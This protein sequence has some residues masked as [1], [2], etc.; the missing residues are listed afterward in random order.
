[1][2]INDTE[3]NLP[4]E[5]KQD[6]PNKI[7][8]YINELQEFKNNE[9]TIKEINFEKE[10]IVFSNGKNEL[11]MNLQFIRN[12]NNSQ[13]TTT[14]NSNETSEMNT[15][16]KFNGVMSD[17]SN[18]NTLTDK[19]NQLGQKQRQSLSGGNN[20]NIF[21]SSKYSDTSSLNQTE[22]SNYSNITPVIYN[23]R[24]DNFSDTSVL[25][26]NGGGLDNSENSDT[27]RSVSELKDRKNKFSNKNT[28]STFKSNL[29]MG[30]F[31]KS[32]NQSGGTRSQLDLKK[33][34]IDAGINS[35]STSS[36]CE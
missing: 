29:D 24:S 11:K 17:T 1:M 5:M 27:L 18:G 32:Q 20:K 3:Q 4:N 14:E 10:E 15:E 31:R 12:K 9:F 21:K 36:I 7:V 30:I 25:G 2:N 19:F 34:M 22:L 13:F 8:G 26:Q 23:N 16:Q 6:L 28:T 35:S 33:K